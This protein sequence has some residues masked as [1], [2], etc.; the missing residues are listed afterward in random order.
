VKSNISALSPAQHPYDNF[1]G[2]QYGQDIDNNELN[3]EIKKL[4]MENQS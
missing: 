4:L 3:E 1:M 2:E